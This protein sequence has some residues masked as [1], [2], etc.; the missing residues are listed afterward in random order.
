MKICRWSD[1]S[2]KEIDSI[3]TTFYI[4][5]GTIDP[6]TDNINVLKGWYNIKYYVERI[7]QISLEN[8]QVYG[9]VENQPDV[10]LFETSLKKPNILSIEL[11]QKT[12]DLEIKAAL[13][14]GV[15]RARDR[16]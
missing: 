14:L 9:I 15:K 13:I 16:I 3:Y 8:H 5:F 10:L 6:S 1:L 12:K 11:I 2:K 7:G 4:C